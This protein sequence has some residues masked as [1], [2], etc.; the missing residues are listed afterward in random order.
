MKKIAFPVRGEF[1]KI[2]KM[3]VDR[4]FVDRRL[5]HTGS[6]PMLLKTTIILTWL[7]VSYV[8]LVF[9]S[10]SLLMAMITGFA[11]AQGVVLVGFNIM[12]DGNHGSYSKRKKINQLMGFTLDLIGGSSLIWR[13]KHNLLHHTYTNVS[14]LDDDLH[15]SGLL[16]LSPTQEWH[17]WHRLQHIYAFPLYSMLTLSWVIYGDLGKLISGQIGAYRL[18]ETSAAEAAFF[19]L[20]KVF[21]LG[22]TIV[23]PLLFH[24][25]LY[26]LIG[27]VA[28]HLVIGSTISIVFQLAHT[29]EGNTFPRPDADT[30]AIHNEWA[31]HQVQST[32]NFAPGNRLITWYLGGLN[33]QIE[34]H[35]FPEI[36]HVHYPAISRIVQETCRDFSIVYASHPSVRSAIAAHYRFLK[37]LGGNTPLIVK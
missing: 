27:F 1:K 5:P 35:L 33:F 11:L 28:I 19:L 6:W 36:S 23:L 8:L 26:V 21:Y 22:Y 15:T 20:A 24:P 37:S 16:R 14:E 17:P 9:F 2:V 18:R 31:I 13:Q 34:H 29:V 4:Y 30:G 32:A 7:A 10:A 3:R 12:H 25:V